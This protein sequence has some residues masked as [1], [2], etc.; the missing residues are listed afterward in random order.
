M[1]ETET[2]AEPRSAGEGATGSR[3][4]LTEDQEREVTR[5]YS[6]TETPGVGNQQAVRDRRVV[7]VPRGAAA[8]CIVAW[9]DGDRRL[10]R[11]WHQG[12]LA[13]HR[14]RTAR[15]TPGQRRGSRFEWHR[16]RHRTSRTPPSEW[17]QRRSQQRDARGSTRQRSTPTWRC[18][19]KWQWYRRSLN[20]D[21][22]GPRT[23]WRSSHRQRWHHHR[24]T[25]RSA[26]GHGRQLIR[27]RPRE[28]ELRRWTQL[29][30]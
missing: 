30:R 28:R 9:A 7:G 16:H 23:T 27:E 13:W 15:P 11:G 2:S 22:H 21:R 1:T 5:L 24:S 10:E 12:G 19:R 25:P 14:H 17:S 18:R 6:E 4:K 20:R 26:S 29:A 8:W 3:R